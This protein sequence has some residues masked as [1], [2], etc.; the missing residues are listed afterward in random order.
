MIAIG[1]S[2]ERKLFIAM[3]K[4][5]QAIYLGLASADS[6]RAYINMPRVQ[7]QCFCKAQHALSEED[8]Y[9][10][11]SF[12][13]TAREVFHAMDKAERVAFRQQSFTF[14]AAEA[15]MYLLL[16]PEAREAYTKLDIKVP[17]IGAALFVTLR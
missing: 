9:A 13:P 14:P 17:P 6:R 7:Q 11:L 15:Q 3:P 4:P 2:A 8:K 16:R 12:E 5:E 1:S 10:F